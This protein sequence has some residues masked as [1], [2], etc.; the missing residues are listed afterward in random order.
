[1][2]LEQRAAGL[3][4]LLRDRDTKFTAVFD[5]VFTAA[6][7]DVIKIPPQA[8]RA[9]AFAERWVA[10]YAANAPTRCS[11]PASGTWRPCSPST[12][13]TTTATAHIAHLASSRP[14]RRRTSLT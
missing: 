2:D 9:N 12:W 7:I 11:S 8:S 6:G 10:P 3:R 13:L 5:A 14:T 4:F 1:M